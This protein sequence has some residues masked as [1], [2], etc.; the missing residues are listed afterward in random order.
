MTAVNFP[1]PEIMD[2]M[3]QLTRSYIQEIGD[4]TVLYKEMQ[5][6]DSDGRVHVLHFDQ[7]TNLVEVLSGRHASLKLQ[8]QLFLITQWVLNDLVDIGAKGFVITEYAIDVHPKLQQA[9]FRG[10]L[11]HGSVLE[12]HPLFNPEAPVQGTKEFSFTLNHFGVVNQIALS[13]SIA[14]LIKKDSP[15]TKFAGTFDVGYTFKWSP[16]AIGVDFEDVD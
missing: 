15:D 12:G 11:T 4:G 9:I 3:D 5:I 8:P 2:S 13:H 1:I 14:N 16:T 7:V 10:K 6:L